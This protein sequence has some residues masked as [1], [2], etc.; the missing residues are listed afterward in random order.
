[1][2]MHSKVALMEPSAAVTLVCHSH[3]LTLY[4]SQQKWT[5]QKPTQWVK[6]TSSYCQYQSWYIHEDS[7]ILFMAE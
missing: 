7:S 3:T 4:Q 1:M 2:L 6:A 5:K